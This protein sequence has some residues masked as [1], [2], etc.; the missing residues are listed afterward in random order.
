[1]GGRRRAAVI[2]ASGAAVKA[3]FMGVCTCLLAGTVGLR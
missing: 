3:A 1:V 2:A